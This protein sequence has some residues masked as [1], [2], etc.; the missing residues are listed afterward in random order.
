MWSDNPSLPRVDGTAGGG[1]RIRPLCRSCC[2]THFCRNSAS[3][4]CGLGCTLGAWLGRPGYPPPPPPFC[5]WCAGAVSGL[6]G[7]PPAPPSSSVSLSVPLRWPDHLHTT[8]LHYCYQWIRLGLP[9]QA[10]GGVT[11]VYTLNI[12]SVVKRDQQETERGKT[13][14]IVCL[15]IP[16]TSCGSRW[17]T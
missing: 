9:R 5:L 13:E 12:I 15:L 16:A 11:S 8:L 17:I 10:P 1:H 3:V 14:N 6:F 7:T 4:S 2:A